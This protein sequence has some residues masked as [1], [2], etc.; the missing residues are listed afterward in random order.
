MNSAQDKLQPKLGLFTVTNIVVANIIGAGIFTTTGYLMDFL[1]NPGLMLSLWIVGGIISFCGA[2]SFGELGATFPNAGGEYVFISKLFHPLLG[3][4][5]GWLSLIVGFSAPIAASAIGFAEYFN[6][7]FPDLHNHIVP[8]ILISQELFTKLLAISIIIIFTVIHSRG[9]VFGGKVQS[10]LTILKIALITGI[11]VAGFSVGKGTFQYLT[12]SSVFQFSYK[13]WKSIGLSLLLI[14]F[15]YSGWSSA[16][17]IGSE[18]IN[19]KK[20]IPLSLL[21]STGAVMVLYILLNLFFVYAIPPA[22]LTGVPEIAG[23]A[24]KRS[25]GA[26]AETVV[27][28]FTSF[29]LIS[30]LSAFI[31]LGPR[32]YYSMAKDGYFFKFAARIH[33]KFKVPVG[34]IVLQ[35][36]IS[37][38][39]VVSGTFEQILIYMGFSLGIFPILA[40]WGVFKLRK[41]G[42]SKMKLPG[43]PVVQ[44]IFILFGVAMLILAFLERPVESIIAII[45]AFSGI[46]VY[47]VFNRAKQITLNQKAN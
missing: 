15:A 26:V 13:G 18:V 5:S 36:V 40:V 17:Y 46:P 47:Y 38:I 35:S 45:T 11:I 33:T 24:A 39:L 29:A 2:I 25:F 21:I 37:M 19:P 22:E 30:S 42:E 6:V 44:I 9:I 41:N 10:T 7:V 28:L 23:L 16:T 3:F 8:T 32:V 43:Y 14:M 4:L 1:G 34:A 31:I 12:E 27:S 20:N